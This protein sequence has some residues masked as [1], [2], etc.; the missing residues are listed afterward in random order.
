MAC[1]AH[2]ISR[3]RQWWPSDSS[4]TRLGP[5][6]GW[7][8]TKEVV[9]EDGSQRDLPSVSNVLLTLFLEGF[10]SIGEVHQKMFEHLRPVTEGVW[11]Q[12]LGVLWLGKLETARGHFVSQWGGLIRKMVNIFDERI[13]QIIVQW[14]RSSSRKGWLVVAA[15]GESAW[16]SLTQSE[17]V[18]VSLS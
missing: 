7:S 17:S 4:N 15:S 6:F 1:L 5:T 3:H 2:F 11:D 14:A 9:F 8:T 13:F 12:C 16:V 18:W 10:L